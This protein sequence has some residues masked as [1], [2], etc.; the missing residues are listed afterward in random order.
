MG[1]HVAS[2]WHGEESQ[3]FCIRAHLLPT[4]PSIIRL[5]VN[6]GYRWHI[7]IIIYSNLTHIVK[8]EIDNLKKIYKINRRQKKSNPRTFFLYYICIGKL[9]YFIFAKKWLY[10][11]NTAKY[12]SHRN[13]SFSSITFK[14]TP[15]IIVIQNIFIRKKIYF[16]IAVD[17]IR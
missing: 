9:L 5:V 3:A 15:N 17:K 7:H 1:T 16:I 2:F 4:L 12:N 10:N 13:F 6:Q 14:A 8:R 11:L